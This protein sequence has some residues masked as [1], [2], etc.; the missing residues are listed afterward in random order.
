MVGRNCGPVYVFFSRCF[1]I[2]PNLWGGPRLDRF[3][4]WLLSCCS[5]LS[6]PG[7][8]RTICVLLRVV[9]SMCGEAQV[10]G[11]KYHLT[12]R[13]NWLHIH[14]L[15]PCLNPLT[16]TVVVMKS[17]EQTHSWETIWRV[18]VI[19]LTLMLVVADLAN[20]KWCKKPE[21]WLKPCH[22]V[23]H[24]RVLSECYP[25]NTNMIGLDDFASLCFGWK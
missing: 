22:I 10:L 4:C 6:S 23:S 15:L 11:V 7:H 24:L 12:V 17:L 16:I 19:G 18:W 14:M 5:D 1:K 3:P 2:L 25:M 13:F 20:T 9:G 21:R 8:Y